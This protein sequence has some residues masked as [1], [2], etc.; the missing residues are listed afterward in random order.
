MFSCRQN[1]EC[2]V[3][4]SCDTIPWDSAYIDIKLTQDGEPT[5]L[6]LYKGYIEDNDIIS[7]DTVWSETT[8]WYWMRVGDRY[9]LEAYYKVG[10][11]TIIALD[12]G[13]L[14]KD[15]YDEC[16]TTCYNEPSLDLDVRKE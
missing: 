9:A 4:S 11:Q 1:E 7:I 15:S 10:P 3:T 6:V 5:V 12:G 2:F 8:W 13:K 14:S 16:G